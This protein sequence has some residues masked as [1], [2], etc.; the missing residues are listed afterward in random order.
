MSEVPGSWERPKDNL[1]LLLASSVSLGTEVQT[2]SGHPAAEGCGGRG[3]AAGSKFIQLVLKSRSF[4]L[5][6]GASLRAV[7][8]RPL[9][10]CEP[11]PLSSEPS[12]LTLSGP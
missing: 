11:H 3:G 4:L 8:K 12:H 5:G 9:H 2:G 10:L 1:F 7:G 6:P